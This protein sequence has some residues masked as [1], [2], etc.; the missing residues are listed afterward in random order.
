MKWNS[1]VKMLGFEKTYTLPFKFDIPNYAQE[2]LEKKT[3]IKFKIKYIKRYLYIYL[4]GQNFLEIYNISPE[5]K[6]ILWINISAPSLGDSLMDLS[7]R[8]MLNDRKVDLFTD[9]KNA[10]LYKDDFIFSTIYTDKNQVDKNK[11]DLVIIDSYSTRSIHIKADIAGL[12]PFVGMFGYYNGPEVNRVLFSFHQM[13]NLLGYRKGKVEINKMAKSSISISTK[14]KKFINKAKLPSNYVAIALGGEWSYRTYNYW[15]KV[16]EEL[17]RKENNLNILLIGSEN[18]QDCE[19]NILDKFP[20][21]NVF[22]CVAKFTFNQT[23]QIIKQAKI[24]LCCDGGLMHSANAVDTT[25]IPLFA[26]LS[27][28]MQLT[29][30]NHSFPLFDKT[31]VNNILFEDILQKFNEAVNI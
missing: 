4:K 17:T 1:G 25:I 14:D 13:N 20:N 16:I 6:E 28:E 21:A 19:K 10:D 7:S 2:F 23:A 30:C 9:N 24:L 11:Y 26:R 3:L 18:A 12:T 5:H 27:E 8:I 22:S 31:D 15:D 29:E